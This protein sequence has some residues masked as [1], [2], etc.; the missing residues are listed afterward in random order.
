[1]YRGVSREKH[2]S[3]GIEDALPSLL[4]PLTLL[5][6]VFL[7]EAVDPCVLL[8]TGA[9]SAIPSRFSRTRCRDAS[10]LLNTS[11]KRS[12][13]SAHSSLRRTL[14]T[15]SCSSTS[16]FEQTFNLK[17]SGNEVYFTA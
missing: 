1:V 5:E 4:A 6:S 15:G 2:P 9:L 7:R 3:H 10:I 16:V 13:S 17:L 11:T 14:V 12:F 8:T